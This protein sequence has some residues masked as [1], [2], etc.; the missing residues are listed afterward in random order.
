MSSFIRCPG[1]NV[2]PTTV[3]DVDQA[4]FGTLVRGPFQWHTNE[5]LVRSHMACLK[6]TFKLQPGATSIQTDFELS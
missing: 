5:P 4:D 3:L 2:L 1:I 6:D